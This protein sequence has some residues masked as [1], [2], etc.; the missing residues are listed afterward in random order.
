MNGIA[1][2]WTR[3]IAF[4]LGCSGGASLAILLLCKMDCVVPTDLCNLGTETDRQGSGTLSRDKVGFCTLNSS[5]EGTTLFSLK[6]SVFLVI[7]R[8]EANGISLYKIES[9]AAGCQW[10][11]AVNLERK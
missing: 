4:T 1:H 8:A 3:A 7:S 5:L 11:H 2:Q 9:T 6:S 10:K